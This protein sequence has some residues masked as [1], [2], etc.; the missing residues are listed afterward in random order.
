MGKRATRAVQLEWSAYDGP[1]SFEEW[2][3]ARS[4]RRR[5]ERDAADAALSGRMGA[6]M[7]RHDDGTSTLAD[8]P[9]IHA[10]LM[11]REFERK[12]VYGR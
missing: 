11:R 7:R 5:E 3:K 2:R 1:M 4:I 6:A 9:L 10:E 8:L 12:I